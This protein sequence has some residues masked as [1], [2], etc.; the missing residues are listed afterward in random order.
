MIVFGQKKVLNTKF[1]I[2]ELSLIEDLA[3]G[4]KY[5]ITR[6]FLPMV[7]AMW[8]SDLY[9]GR[10]WAL[11]HICND[12]N[13]IKF[14]NVSFAKQ[15]FN[16]I[17]SPYDWPGTAERSEQTDFMKKI[18]VEKDFTGYSEQ[19]NRLFKDCFNPLALNSFHINK[20]PLVASI[21]RKLASDGKFEMKLNVLTRTVNSSRSSATLSLQIHSR[22][23]FDLE[24]VS[25]KYRRMYNAVTGEWCA[26]CDAGTDCVE[27]ANVRNSIAALNAYDDP[28]VLQEAQSAQ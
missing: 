20:S 14:V 21:N 16:R 2:K 3:E 28:A 15:E 12:N 22:D 8:Q 6:Y 26:L 18:S 17:V 24:N 11:L 9:P 13:G 27:C 23:C 10:D 4:R 7:Y 19:L 25:S 5:F 1:S